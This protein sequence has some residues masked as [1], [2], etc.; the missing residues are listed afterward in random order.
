LKITETPAQ[1][2]WLSKGNL[3][4]GAADQKSEVLKRAWPAVPLS[5]ITLLK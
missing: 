2:P 1:S 3:S 5:A 4:A